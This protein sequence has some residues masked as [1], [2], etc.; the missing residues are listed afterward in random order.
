MTLCS[1]RCHRLSVMVNNVLSPLLPDPYHGHLEGYLLIC[2]CF[3]LAAALVPRGKKSLN[4]GKIHID[5]WLFYE[6][7]QALFAGSFWLI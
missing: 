7:H 2:G 1:D 3:K 5:H 6:I 4:Y